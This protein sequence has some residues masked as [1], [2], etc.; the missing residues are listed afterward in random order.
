MKSLFCTFLVAAA[1]MAGCDKSKKM[2]GVPV[3]FEG[4]SVASVASDAKTKSG[5]P[6]DVYEVNSAGGT[7]IL[8]IVGGGKLENSGQF[9]KLNGNE[10]L[11]DNA[12]MKNSVLVVDAKLPA[13]LPMAEI[14][15][16]DAK[17]KCKAG[18]VIDLPIDDVLNRPRPGMPIP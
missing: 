16:S 11:V 4:V 3:K 7:A 1:L 17:A 2:S 18:M 8:L 9:L 6:V 12:L 14:L 13:P 5:K 10:F 15:P